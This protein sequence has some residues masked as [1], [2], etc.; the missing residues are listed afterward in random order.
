MQIQSIDFTQLDLRRINNKS[1]GNELNTN[2]NDRFMK[3]E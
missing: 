1:L 2:I 3:H